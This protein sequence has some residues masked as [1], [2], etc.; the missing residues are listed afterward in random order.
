MGVCYSD[1]AKS[2][3]LLKATEGMLRKNP[4]ILILLSTLFANL[5][6]E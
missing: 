4:A 3:N 6:I 1:T 5:I 2:S